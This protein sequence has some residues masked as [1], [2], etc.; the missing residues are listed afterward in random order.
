M[1]DNP[2]IPE[3]LRGLIN[4]AGLHNALK[5]LEAPDGPAGEKVDTLQVHR[6]EIP[7]DTPQ[8][9]AAGLILVIGNLRRDGEGAVRLAERLPQRR[10]GHAGGVRISKI[11]VPDAPF[12]GPQHQPNGRRYSLTVIG[13]LDGE[14]GCSQTQGK[15]ILKA[16]HPNILIAAPPPDA[17]AEHGRT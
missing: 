11:H 7:F 3:P 6:L 10:H 16:I 15:T 4:A 8:S 17:G 12:Q 2:L 14:A 13:A 1:T 5:L 9:V